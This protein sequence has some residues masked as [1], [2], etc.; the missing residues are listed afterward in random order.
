MLSN[1]LH[2]S[3]AAHNSNRPSSLKISDCILREAN[4]YMELSKSRH[5]NLVECLGYYTRDGPVIGY[6]LKK[7][8]ETLFERLERGA[9]A[10]IGSLISDI[11][12]ALNH[13][14]SMGVLG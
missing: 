7:Y 6:F 2:S 9:Y 4:T 5:P 3:I 11:R 1:K 10:D 12:S 8:E 14:H 13:F